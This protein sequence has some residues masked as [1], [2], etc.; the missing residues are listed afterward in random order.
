MENTALHR[1][2]PANC[3]QCQ[4]PLLSNHAS[5]HQTHEE[6]VAIS[7]MDKMMRMVQASGRDGGWG[8]QRFG[9]GHW[10]FQTFL[11][12]VECQGPVC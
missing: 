5:N 2:S 6:G 12:S 11:I 8:W 10:F 1:W 4:V 7:C 3:Q 9:M